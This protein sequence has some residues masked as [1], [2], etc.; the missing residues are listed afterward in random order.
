M[1]GEQWN[2]GSALS[3]AGGP[4]CITFYTGCLENLS[5]H[6]SDMLGA[7]DFTGL[8]QWLRVQFENP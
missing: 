1:I 5:N 7:L 6:R 4:W 8:Q 3:R 2:Q